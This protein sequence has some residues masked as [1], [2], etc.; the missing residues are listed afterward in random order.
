MLVN[1]CISQASR[2]PLHGDA[3]PVSPAGLPFTGTDMVTGILT[4][5]VISSPYSDTEQKLV[6]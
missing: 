6:K 5:S 4:P 2:L 3:E 1:V